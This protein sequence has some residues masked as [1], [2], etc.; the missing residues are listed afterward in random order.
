MYSD[1]RSKAGKFDVVPLP[2][3]R[4]GA[5]SEPM[6]PAV[7]RAADLVAQAAAT[8]DELVAYGQNISDVSERGI[9]H[10]RQLASTARDKVDSLQK[11]LTALRTDYEGLL[12]S[13]N[14]RIDTLERTVKEQAAE[15]EKLRAIMWP[16]IRS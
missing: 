7:S 8:I 1:S 13:S 6:P 14:E 10:Y 12:A 9:L 2:R 15:L 5:V 4:A 16:G 11:Q 3:G